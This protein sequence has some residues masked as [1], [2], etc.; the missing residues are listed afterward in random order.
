MKKITLF[1]LLFGFSLVYAQNASETA[2]YNNINYQLHPLDGTAEVI[3]TP[4]ISGDIMIPEQIVVG[5]KTYT[6][7]EI[8]DKAF[9]GNKKLMNVV[10][11]STLVRV[12]RTAFDGTG[13]MANKT[14]WN[15]G[16]LIIDSCLIATAKNI[17]S[18]YEVPTEVRVIACGA[19]EGNKTIKR[20]DLNEGLKRLDHDTFRGC[21]N[22]TKLT[23]PESV[24][25]IGQDVL[26]DC[27][28]Y[29]N[30][31]R[32]KKGALYV[33]GCLMTVNDNANAKFVFPT[34]EPTR[35]IACGAFSHNKKV[36]LIQLPTTITE[37][38][39]A[40]F[41]KCE[42]LEEVVIPNSVTRVGMYAFYECPKCAKHFYL[43]VSGRLA[44]VLSTAALTCAN[45]T[46]QKT[47][48]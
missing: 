8:G 7:T 40:L 31:K 43:R 41:Y 23:I 33:D 34:K 37:I 13:V 2:M 11:P 38:P 32:W 17:K 1:I 28:I 15:D 10:L 25:W 26:T 35:V 21:K 45:S 18:K 9:R 30:D 24:T 39:N 19:F 14:L 20:V 44:P 46:Y 4:Y 12:Y 42:T 3:E 29:L 36:R 48:H 16:V 47:L 6:V 27:G 5:Q 22:L